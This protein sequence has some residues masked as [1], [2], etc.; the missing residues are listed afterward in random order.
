M[1]AEPLHV[2]R[3]S[4]TSEPGTRG[5]HGGSRGRAAGKAGLPVVRPAALTTP[6]VPVLSPDCWPS[7]PFTSYS[8][9][10]SALSFRLASLCD[11]DGGAS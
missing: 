1:E 3:Q 8:Y 2:A 11:D 6:C 7:K 10:E 5:R 9:R 4:L